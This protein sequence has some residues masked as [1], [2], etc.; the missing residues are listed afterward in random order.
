MRTK[1]VPLGL[2]LPQAGFP[3]GATNSSRDGEVSVSFPP[4][5]PPYPSLKSALGRAIAP[6][7][8]LPQQGRLYQ[9][10]VHSGMNGSECAPMNLSLG[11][12]NLQFKLPAQRAAQVRPNGTGENH[13]EGTADPYTHKNKQQLRLPTAG[14]RMT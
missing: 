7:Q 11:A 6:Q 8:D 12:G 5:A 9:V 4:H 13:G 3:N 2:S 10:P 14:T 1:H